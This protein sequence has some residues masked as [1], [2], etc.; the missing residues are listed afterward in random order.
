MHILFY[1]PDNRSQPWLE[2]G[3][4]IAGIV[5]PSKEY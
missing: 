3:E 1:S 4:P 2:R 5:D